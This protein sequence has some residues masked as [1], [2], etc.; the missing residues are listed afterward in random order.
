MRL[1]DSLGQPGAQAIHAPA[2]A[3]PAGLG[4]LAH[5]SPLPGLLRSHIPHVAAVSV[6]HYTTACLLGWCGAQFANFGTMGAG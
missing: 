5:H 1:S 6:S 3:I 2:L 4:V